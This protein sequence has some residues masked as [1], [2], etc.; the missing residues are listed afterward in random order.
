MM[1]WK[2]VTPFIYMAILGIYV[3]FLGRTFIF[4]NYS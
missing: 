4:E 3:K 2:K 1:V